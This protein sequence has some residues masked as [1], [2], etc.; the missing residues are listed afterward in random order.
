MIPNG[1]NAAPAEVAFYFISL[2]R[3]RFT[4]YV[5]RRRL[6]TMLKLDV[7]V[8]VCRSPVENGEIVA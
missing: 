4:Q 8:T 2:P 1:N 5:P 6:A 7:Y 3:P